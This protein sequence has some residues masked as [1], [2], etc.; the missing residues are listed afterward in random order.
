MASKAQEKYLKEVDR[1]KD[2]VILPGFYFHKNGL[3]LLYEVIM[4]DVD[5]N[6][7]IL[8]NKDGFKVTKTLHWS[9]KNL[10]GV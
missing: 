6:Q 3:Q 2:I 1:L 10:V 5:N 4:V 7:V 9:K 8:K